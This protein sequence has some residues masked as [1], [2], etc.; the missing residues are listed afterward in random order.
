M[1]PHQSKLAR[2]LER[3]HPP[4]EVLS[5]RGTFRRFVP[6]DLNATLELKP[7][8]LPG[9][10]GTDLCLE[11]L[12]TGADV[13]RNHVAGWVFSPSQRKLAERLLACVQAG[14]AFTGYEVKTDVHGK[15]YIDAKQA[16]FFHR[17]HMSGELRKLG[18]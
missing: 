2:E 16:G 8:R 10:S 14:R 5:Q 15:T 17:K 9:D 13:D 7:S 12:Y 1:T 3:L 11:V 18:F 4:A 6:G